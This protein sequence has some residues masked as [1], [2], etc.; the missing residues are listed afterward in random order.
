[1]TAHVTVGDYLPN[2][3]DTEDSNFKLH[4]FRFLKVS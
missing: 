3:A 4:L 1:M 2:G